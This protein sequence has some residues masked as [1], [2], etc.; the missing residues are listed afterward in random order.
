MTFL[1]VPLSSSYSRRPALPINSEMEKR[2][3]R[4]REHRFKPNETVTVTVLGW[5]PGPILQASILDTS[6]SGLRLH[7]NLPLPLGAFIEI[8][9]N[10]T[11]SRGSV[12]WCAA[13][14]SDHSEEDS[15]ELRIQVSMTSLSR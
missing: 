6:G 2:V 10:R 3:Q 4:R 1:S 8:E 14:P 5:A 7:T 13:Q 12:C 11:V 9:S 15:Y